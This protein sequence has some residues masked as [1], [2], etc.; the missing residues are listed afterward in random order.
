VFWLS[1]A[2]LSPTFG[3]TVTPKCHSRPT[4]Y[5]YFSEITI[6]LT[7]PQAVPVTQEVVIVG[8]QG[9][10]GGVGQGGELAIVRVC[11]KR[12]PLGMSRG[13]IAILGAEEVRHGVGPE[14]RDVPQGGHCQ[15]VEWVVE[16]PSKSI[17][18]TLV[19]ISCRKP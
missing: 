14:R 6:N 7:M 17:H 15:L 11:H 13:G 12:E 1:M 10:A 16:R 9:G 4:R 3:D 19:H 5:L 2:L 18:M 8:D